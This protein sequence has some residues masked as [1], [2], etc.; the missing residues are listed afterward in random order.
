MKE[1]RKGM[2]VK[3]STPLNEDEMKIRMKV[4]EDYGNDRVLVQDRFE[5]LGGTRVLLKEWIEAV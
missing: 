3:Y 4:L 5:G 1:F 2:Y